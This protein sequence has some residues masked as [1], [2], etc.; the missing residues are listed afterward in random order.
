MFNTFGFGGIPRHMGLNSVSHCFPLNGNTS[1]PRIQ[2]VEGI[3]AAYRQT[4][5]QI[6]LG[7][8]TNFTPVIEAFGG[9]ASANQAAYKYQILLII[10]DGM[11]TD[12]QQTINAIV[13]V[14]MLPT[15]I[16]IVG[17]G[18]ADFS[19]MEQLDGDDGGLRDSFG[20]KAVRDCV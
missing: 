9:F 10:T 2:G 19:S 6:G 13:K 15:S 12:M 5:A 7:G 3:C 1:D 20:N 11:I 4:L 14:S 16:I 18:N 8:P 17:V